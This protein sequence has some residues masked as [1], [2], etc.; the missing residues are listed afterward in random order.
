MQRLSSDKHLS[1]MLESELSATKTKLELTEVNL[2]DRQGDIER[3]NNKF[4]KL[5]S[6]KEGMELELDRLKIEQWK[7]RT[8]IENLE[9]EKQSLT[10]ELKSKE[11]LFQQ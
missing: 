4:Q 10:K 9:G 5:A 1:I 6:E 7:H 2:K 11:M 8:T 3:L